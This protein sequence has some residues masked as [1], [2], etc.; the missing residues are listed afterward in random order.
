ME[1]VSMED[2]IL[3]LHIDEEGVL[4]ATIKKSGSTNVYFLVSP[5]IIVP[6]TVR[7]KELVVKA[8]DATR[9]QGKSNPQFRILYLSDFAYDEDESIFGD[10]P[11]YAY[12]AAEPYLRPQRVEITVRGGDSAEN[13]DV[14]RQS[15]WLDIIPGKSLPTAFTPNGDEINDI[16][17]WVASNYKVEIYN[18]LGTL[19][20]KGN[21]GWDGKYKGNYVQPGVY[22]YFATS[23]EGV[24]YKGSVEVIRT[25]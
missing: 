12:C 18:R 22:Y 17:P 5:A 2:D 7:Q 16:W 24:V 4:F 15:G 19:L 25:K 6:V 9:E 21:N 8:E 13:Y 14:V 1:D 11:L 23:P 10:D 20:Y 3:D